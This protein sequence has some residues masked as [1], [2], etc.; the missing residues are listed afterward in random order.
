MGILIYLKQILY[1]SKYAQELTKNKYF[2]MIFTAFPTVFCFT[3]DHHIS[4]L[5]WTL[6]KSNI[7]K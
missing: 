5:T 7:N 2:K 6:I 3:V 4:R 1:T